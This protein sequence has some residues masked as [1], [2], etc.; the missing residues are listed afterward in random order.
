MLTAD[1]RALLREVFRAARKKGWTRLHNDRDYAEPGSRY[2]LDDRSTP[3]EL[4]KHGWLKTPI[5]EVECVD[6]PLA[7]D[8]LV[9]V[10]VL[11]THLSSAYKSGHANGHEQAYYASK[12]QWG[13]RRAGF[14]SVRITSDT[15]ARSLLRNFVVPAEMV[16]REVGP[17]EVVATNDDLLAKRDG[18]VVR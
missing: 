11:P 3:I 10:G 4:D 7:V 17:W 16:M 5:S 6:V 14:K 12:T 2:W 15:K 1:D 8:V 9:A 18:E 13:I